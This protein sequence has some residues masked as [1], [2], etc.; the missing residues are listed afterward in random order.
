M[1]LD[2]GAASSS[3]DI[4][5]GRPIKSLN[6]RVKVRPG[7]SGDGSSFSSVTGG[8]SFVDSS[9]NVKEGLISSGMLSI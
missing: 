1:N 5:W 8:C 7:D 4:S 9:V 6:V 3:V 2:A